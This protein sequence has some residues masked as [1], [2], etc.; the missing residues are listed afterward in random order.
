MEKYTYAVLGAGRQGEAIVYDLIR[1]GGAKEVFLFEK[2]DKQLSHVYEKIKRLT[3]KNLIRPIPL[4]F[5]EGRENFLKILAGRDA[6]IISSLPYYFNEDLAKLATEAVANFCDLGGNTDITF[7]ELA[8]YE[9]AQKAGI[10][11]IPDCGLM[12]GAGN[13]LAAYAISQFDECDEIKIYVGGLPQWDKLPLGYKLTFSAEGLINEYSGKAN[14]LK[15]GEIVK[16]DALTQ[17]E[18]LE[19]IDGA[20][21]SYEAFITSGGTSTAPWSFKGRVK[22]YIEKTIRYKGHLEQIILLKQL[23][24]FEKTP[25]YAGGTLV[26]PRTFLKVILEEKLGA[27]CEMDS[28]DMVI[29]ILIARGKNKGKNEAFKIIW[30]EY[31][32]ENNR[33]FTAMQKTTGFSAAIVAIMQAKGK[34]PKGALSPEIAVS[35][36]MF[37]KELEKRGFNLTINRF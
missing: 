33:A 17:V 7:R 36:Q 21:K 29:F 23:G 19:D 24:L 1:F 27:R 20:L 28:K 25:V 10:S 5:P 32:D 14:I 26:F 18:S 9:K 6:S 30:R 15:D 8:L 11:I 37:L 4:S 35:P 2:D 3:N 13:I 31:E 34:V 22:N 16:V 12:P